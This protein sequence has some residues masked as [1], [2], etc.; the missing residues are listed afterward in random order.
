MTHDVRRTMDNAR[1]MAQAPHR[2]FVC[3]M[4]HPGHHGEQHDL[5]YR[6]IQGC[7]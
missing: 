6:W 2:E 5:Q 1:D 7:S 4:Y 3:T